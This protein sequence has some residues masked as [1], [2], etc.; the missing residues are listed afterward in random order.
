MKAAIFVQWIVTSVVSFSAIPS[1]LAQGG[2]LGQFN[3]HG[4]IGAPKIP[5]SA[6]YNPADESYTLT[7]GGRNI[8]STNDE[9]Q[10][11]W[12]K[13]KGDFIVRA[14]VEFVGASAE[15]HRKI[16][17]MARSSLDSDA[18]YVDAVEHGVG[19][20]S[21][22]YRQFAGSNTMEFVLPITNADIIQFERR[23]TNYIFSAAHSGDTF[24]STNFSDIEMPD[25]VFLG[26]FLC[27]HNPDAREEAI[28]HDVEIIR[29]ARPDFV[30]YRDY[31]GSLLHIL[32]VE[33][34]EMETVNGSAEPFEAPNWTRDGSALIYNISGR[35]GDWGKLVRF[36]LATKKESIIA[37]DF[38]NRNNND[39]VISFDGTMLAIS[40]QGAGTGGQSCIF[41]V[42]LGGGTPKRITTATPSY[43]HGWSPDGKFLVFTGGRNG[44]FDVYK[45]P[46]DGGD[47]IRL[48]DSNGLNDGSEYSPDGNYVY[49]NSSRTGK[50]QIW[51]MKP[52]GTEQEQV[53]HDE[54]ND[55]FPH[56]SPD[57]KWIVFISFPPDID[58]TTHPYYKEC[59]LRLMSVE[60]GE[61]KVIAYIY[62][63]Q[64]SMNVG[65]WSPDSKRIAFVSNTD[66]SGR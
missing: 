52:D 44:K 1:I 8:W 28:F 6:T 57:G 60:G 25:E 38:A 4:D 11:L 56:I 64:G 13:M 19:L 7:A 34:G 59:Y 37:T 55:W 32:D 33:N 29:P 9:F 22:Q 17:W 41:T 2:P 15:P 45:I 27:A 62:G 10:F 66:M 16:G 12:R 30:P 46:S 40:G 47:E 20:T 65:S 49:F 14:R 63:G 42:P 35:S 39:H 36:D 43:A 18:T 31:I 51:R 54:F 58:P 53:T 61:P 26:L 3:G 24:V 23:G 5:G 48:T 21:L 50:M